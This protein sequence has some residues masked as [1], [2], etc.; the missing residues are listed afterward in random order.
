MNLKGMLIETFVHMPPMAVLEGLSPEQAVRTPAE[1]LHS[2]AAIL[3]HM[4][5]WQAWFLDRCTGT[6]TPMPQSAGAGWPAVSAGGWNR[7]VAQFGEGLE[8]AAALGA[9]PV[10]S[11]AEVTPPIEFPALSH[12]TIQEA[13]VHMAQHNSHHLGQIITTRQLIGLWPPPAGSFTW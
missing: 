3:A 12:Y 10:A 9:D 4:E 7:L 2:A 8:R 6:P 1:G 11:S 13:L 5:F